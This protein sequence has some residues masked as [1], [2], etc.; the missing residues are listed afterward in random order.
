MRQEQAIVSTRTGREMALARYG[1]S[2][3]RCTTARCLAAGC[4]TTVPGP[5]AGFGGTIALAGFG[6]SASASIPGSL[7]QL[8]VAPLA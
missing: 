5:L 3:S 6:G 8:G 4:S 7:A 1:G 2:A